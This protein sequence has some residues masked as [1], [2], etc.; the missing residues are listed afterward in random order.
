MIDFLAGSHV[1]LNRTIR[2]QPQTV[3]KVRSDSVPQVS[4]EENRLTQIGHT[5]EYDNDAIM[6]E[7]YELQL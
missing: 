1:T 2:S 6:F 7:D 3:V 4:S 5:I